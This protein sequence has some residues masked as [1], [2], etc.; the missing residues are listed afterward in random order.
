MIQ[1][2]RFSPLPRARFI[3][4]PVGPRPLLAGLL[5]GLTVWACGGEEAAGPGQQQQP[6]PPTAAQ[7]AFIVGPATAEAGVS[8]TPAVVVTIQDVLGN[9]VTDATDA[10]MVAIGANPGGGTLSGT[11]KVSAV[12]GIATF[13]DIR[14]DLTGSGYT[15]VAT[16]GSLP[17][18]TSA[19][20]DIAFTFA[21]VI[22]GGSTTCG[23]QITGAAYC[24]G[25]NEAGNVGDG[26]KTGSPGK[27]LPTAVSGGLTFA[28][29]SGA[30]D[31][32]CGVT[33]SGE[34]YCW[35]GNEGGR[36]G[37]GTTT[38]RLTPV[39]VSGALSF[40][41]L[42][43]GGTFT[44]GVTTGGEA[45]CWGRNFDGQLG[46]GSTTN[47][48]TPVAVSGSLNFATVSAG[49]LSHNCGVTTDGEVY[50]WG[51]STSGASGSPTSERRLVPGGFPGG[52]RFAMVSADGHTCGVT[53]GGEAYCWGRNDRGQLG[54]TSVG[55]TCG[56]RSCSS[57]PVRVESNLSFTAVT[58]G[59]SHTCGVTA[60]GEAY[61]WGDNFRGQLGD[62]DSTTETCEGIPCSTTP[63]PVF[64]ELS[65]ASIS[66]AGRHTCGVTTDGSTYC[67]GDNLRGQLGDGTTTKSSVPVRVS[68]PT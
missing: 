34:G 55:E 59:G 66:A 6:P 5:I 58:V 18:A 19:A 51:G 14:I 44:C 22:A 24:W 16:S 46:D 56:T 7:L 64:G 60:G 63:V 67:W 62:G 10:V 30:L 27:L 54:V 45:Y 1:R 29:V 21:A 57:T 43:A 2:N 15:L 23:L 52:L 68:D 40:A 39:A 26:T 8:I 35:G 13:S 9:V 50:C 32:T 65:F 47:R 49:A 4:G 42:S 33:T 31:H 12:G 28:V 37:D 53:T 20:F 38:E 36:L 61:C 48:L 25:R 17:S 41:A 3:Q 11:T